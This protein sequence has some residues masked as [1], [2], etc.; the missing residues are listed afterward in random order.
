[1][2]LR[3]KAVTHRVV[4][5]RPSVSDWFIALTVTRLHYDDIEGNKSERDGQNAK[6]RKKLNQKERKVKREYG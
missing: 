1:M 3:H 2:A 4:Y 6:C 5:G